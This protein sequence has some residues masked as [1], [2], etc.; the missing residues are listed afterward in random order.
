LIVSRNVAFYQTNK[1]ILN[2][3]FSIIVK[4][5]LQPDEMASQVTFSLQ[6]VIW[7]PWSK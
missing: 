5:S 1:F 6:A 3:Y 4:R 7:D 2:I